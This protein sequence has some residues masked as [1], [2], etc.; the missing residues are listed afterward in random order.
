[1]ELLNQKIIKGIADQRLD[2]C[3]SFGQS[4]A[5]LLFCKA[6]R[7]LLYIDGRFILLIAEEMDAT[8][9]LQLLIELISYLRDMEEA[10]IIYVQKNDEDADSFIY[11]ERCNDMKWMFAS[12]SYDLGNGCTIKHS[13]GLF[14]LND[15]QGK[16]VLS[17]NVELDFLTEELRLYFG[18]RLFPTSALKDFIKH[19]FLSVNDYNNRQALRMSRWSIAVALLIACISPIV[20]IFM[21][22]KLG[23]TTLTP[24]QYDLLIDEIR[25]DDRLDEAETTIIKQ[26]NNIA[27]L[28]YRHEQDSIKSLQRQ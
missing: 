5:H 3:I 22:N 13:N 11:Y 10:H 27:T 19:G 12:Q 6:K 1:M 2:N 26:L 25:K 15:V 4:I 21:S 18:G 23:E 20:S 8:Q 9:E 16:V 14:L 17:Q 28:I 24:K 7:A